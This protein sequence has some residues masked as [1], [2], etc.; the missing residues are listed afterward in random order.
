MPLILPTIV[1]PTALA[2]ILTLSIA[3]VGSNDFSVGVDAG[4]HHAVAAQLSE[5]RQWPLPATPFLYGITHY[6]PAAHV[7]GAAFGLAAG[8]TFSGMLLV[9]ALALVVA[10][11]TLSYFIQR[12]SPAETVGSIVT[13][14]VL[15]AAFRK[16]R[17]LIGNEVVA[18][19]F[20]GQFAGTAALLACFVILAKLRWSFG[21]VDSP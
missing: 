9:N 17:F 8:S 10:G 7:L 20:Y 6:P 21:G 19:F 12:A 15:C 16:H 3:I 1:R 4:I 13:F 5:H 2:A 11:L 14:L 18:N